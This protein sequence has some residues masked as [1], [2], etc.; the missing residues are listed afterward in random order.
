MKAIVTTSLCAVLAAACGD[1]TNPMDASPQNDAASDRAVLLDAADESAMD[2]ATLD[3]DVADTGSV[4]TTEASA[5]G[6]SM[7]VIDVPGDSGSADVADAAAD[8][9]STDAADA[10]RPPVTIY[11]IVL[12]NLD[13]REVV[14][15]A[16]APYLN[17]LLA[18]NGLATNYRDVAHPG[19]PNRLEMISGG[20]Q[21][22]GILEYGPTAAP[23]FPSASP[24]LGGQLEAAGIAWRAYGENM[25]TPC[26]LSTTGDYKPAHVPFLYFSDVQ[27]ASGALCAARVVDLGSLSA[28]IAAGTSRYLWIAPS[29][30]HDGTSPATDPVLALQQ[31]DTWLSTM[32]PQILASSAYRAN[33]VLFITVDQAMG[34]AGDSADQVPMIVL[35]SR[36]VSAGFSSSTSYTHA[37]YL[38]T[39]EDLLGLARLGEAIG[40]PSLSAFLR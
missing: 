13:Y 16:N 36:I 20:T 35:S 2:V 24:S 14:G 11:T 40:A 38:A 33:G 28:D 27:L 23:Y 17:S 39:V 3:E 10:G 7:D 21:Y 34:R 26:N 22:P 12:S 1:R 15:S 18:S 29:N 8:S 6:G 37:S 25:G 19:L 4:D 31:A 9:G 30:I 5:D 32:V